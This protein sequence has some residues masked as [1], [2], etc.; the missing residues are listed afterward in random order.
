MSEKPEES[1]HVDPIE[2]E[3]A[4][5]A[6]DK[7]A[8]ALLGVSGMGCAHCAMR[9]RNGLLS[10]DGVLL[11]EVEEALRMARVYFDPREVGTDDLVRA[12]AAAGGKGKHEY[13]AWVIA[14]RNVQ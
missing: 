5:D 14:T 7:S 1:C 3:I 13:R 4:P 10:L 9:V 12:V 11:A 8:L 2:K 6:L